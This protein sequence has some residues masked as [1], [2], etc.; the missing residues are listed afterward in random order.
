[1]SKLLI[2]ASI[3]FSLSTTAL[4][5][6]F[7]QP[8]PAVGALNGA[9]VDR[10]DIMPYQPNA[11]IA[12]QRRVDR[13]TVRAALAKARATNIAAFRDYQKKGVFPN[14]TFK[15]GKVNVWVDTDGNF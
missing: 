14:N 10:A 3:F 13:A 15:P 5:S 2:A 8:P 7:A 11:L 6:D 9:A 1:M 12:P 4:A